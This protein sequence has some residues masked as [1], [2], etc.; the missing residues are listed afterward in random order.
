MYTPDRVENPSLSSRHLLSVSPFREDHETLRL[1]VEP[2]KVLITEA[3]SRRDA[4]WTMVNQRFSLILCEA[5][6]DW[7]DILSYLAEVLDPPQLVITSCMDERLWAEALNL[8]SWDVLVKPFDR[9]EV[10]RVVQSA[11]HHRNERLRHA[12]A[13]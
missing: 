6:L 8:G 4:L 13:A 11:L 1:F 7:Q 12:T 2:L 9:A 10:R 5:H 3:C